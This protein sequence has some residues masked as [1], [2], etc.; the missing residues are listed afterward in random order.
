MAPFTLEEY[1]AADLHKVLA[2]LSTA[3]KISLLAGPD[4]WTT[5]PLPRVG[6]PRVK[7]SDGPNGQRRC[8]QLRLLLRSPK[9]NPA[10]VRGSSHFLPYVNLGSEHRWE[11]ADPRVQDTCQ[12]YPLRDGAC[13]VRS[14]LLWE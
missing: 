1:A 11:G 13:G 7:F 9:S 2:S 14:L 8:L 5:T 10:G 4:W 3:E 12:R 6:V